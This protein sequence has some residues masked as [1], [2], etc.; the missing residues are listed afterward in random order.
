MYELLFPR[1][2][3]QHDQY[4]HTK[5]GCVLRFLICGTLMVLVLSFLRRK[6]T[7]HES[8]TEKI[9]RGHAIYE[10]VSLQHLSFL[11]VA[12]ELWCT[13]EYTIKK[14]KKPGH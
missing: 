11:I 3:C 12:Q 5:L 8:V 1:I 13:H 7:T 9:S 10:A 2:S 14:K 4:V 6:G